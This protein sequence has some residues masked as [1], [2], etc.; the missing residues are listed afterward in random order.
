MLID[1]RGKSQSVSEQGWHRWKFARD[2]DWLKWLWNEIIILLSASVLGNVL[3]AIFNTSSSNPQINPCLQ[4]GKQRHPKSC[5]SIK[6]PLGLWANPSHGAIFFFLWIWFTKVPT[7]WWTGSLS[8]FLVAL[9]V[10]FQPHRKK[11]DST[12]DF[13]WLHQGYTYHIYI[14]MTLHLLQEPFTFM[15]VF[16]PHNELWRG[17]YYYHPHFIDHKWTFIRHLPP[18]KS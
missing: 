9:N 3:F 14:C 8:S 17:E 15:T 7:M 5:K 16:D 1:Q 18:P 11:A 10:G 2:K 4:V 12:Q 6:S 13:M